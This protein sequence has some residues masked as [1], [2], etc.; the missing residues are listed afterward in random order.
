MI[1][2]PVLF[3]VFNR[4][5]TTTLVMEAIRRARPS[6][7]Y[8]AAD[9][10]REGRGEEERCEEVRRI[11]TSIDWPCAIDTLF[12]D[13]NLGCGLGPRTAKDWFFKHEEGGIILEDDC[14]PSGSFFRYCAELL[15]RY[16]TDERIMGIDGSSFHEQ[17]HRLRESY[18]F[19]QYPNV[20]GWAT[21][22]RAWALYDWEMSQWPKFRD[23]QCLRAWSEGDSGFERY[24]IDIFDQVSQ[25]TIDCWDYQWVFSCWLHHGLTCHPTRNLVSNI[26]FG[27]DATHTLNPIDIM[28]NWPAG[29]I[30][31]PLIHP[32]HCARD[33]LADARTR[34]YANPETF[35][36]RSL[37]GLAVSK[38][39]RILRS[40]KLI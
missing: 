1:S 4:P 2:C 11:A 22:R 25:G 15:D 34:M 30:E 32:E 39:K 29:E 14:V 10:P 27:A 9:G 31:F 38:T 37:V 7:L 8:V 33:V 6:R 20:W 28:A 24:W 36:H 35:A 18:C 16:A 5:Q 40:A 21:W 17:S 19:S 3:I 13:R 12:R 23:T 26:G